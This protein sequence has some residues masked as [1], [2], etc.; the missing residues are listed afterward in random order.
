MVSRTGQ[1]LN[2]TDIASPLGISIPT[3]TEW[4]NILEATHQVILVPPFFEN[5]GKRLIKSPKIY[6][7]DSGFAAHLL[8]FESE[9][10]LARSTFSGPL[11]ESFVASEIVKAEFN[12]G[13]RK[14][15][16]YFRDRPGLEVDFVVPTGDRRL[17]LIEAKASRTLRPDDALNLLRLQKSIKRYH[18]RSFIVH[19]PAKSLEKLTVLRPGVKAVSYEKIPEILRLE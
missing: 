15:L 7:T 16:Y 13:K 10:A 14:E 6:F 5:F 19:P 17:V 3:V 1:V 8:G 2:R 12:A 18:V 9:K 4:L 11:F